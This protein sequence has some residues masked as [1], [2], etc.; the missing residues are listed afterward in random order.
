MSV[1]MRGLGI[2]N[3][4]P[5][6]PYVAYPTTRTYIRTYLPSLAITSQLSNN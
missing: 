4:E 2:S 3:T 6:D 5:L 1:N